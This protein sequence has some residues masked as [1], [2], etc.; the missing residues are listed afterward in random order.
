MN[1]ENIVNDGELDDAVS[2]DIIE[3]ASFEEEEESPTQEISED[4]F[5]Q[6]QAEICIDGEAQAEQEAEESAENEYSAEDFAKILQ[7]PMFAVFARGRSGEM[8]DIMRDFSTMM[9]A[10]QGMLSQDARMRFTPSAGAY[11]GGIALSE[12]QKS[13]ARSAGMSYREYYDII[14][15]LPTK[16]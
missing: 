4:A 2:E 12:R 7:N 3:G 11:S 15:M 13:I 1:E 14:S 16:K 8:T 9:E 10:G 6:E 5:E